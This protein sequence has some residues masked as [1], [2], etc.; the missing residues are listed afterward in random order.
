MAHLDQLKTV[1]DRLADAPTPLETLIDRLQG[2]AS[3]TLADSG[4]ARLD[5]GSLDRIA[6]CASREREAC[7]ARMECLLELLDVALAGDRANIPDALL[8]ATTQ[9][10]LRL[11]KDAGRWHRLADNAAYYRD[12]PA[13]AERIAWHE[14]QVR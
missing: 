1:G 12:R 5:S 6:G 8:L 4:I 11:L 13:V 3:S 2:G 9:H 10:V 7:E 14:A